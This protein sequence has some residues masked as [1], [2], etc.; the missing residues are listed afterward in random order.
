[1]DEEKVSKQQASCEPYCHLPS[2]PPQIAGPTSPQL[3]PHH[4]LSLSLSNYTTHT[5]TFSTV[6]SHLKMAPARLVWSFDMRLLV[7]IL[8]DPA[9]GLTPAHR[10][11]AFNAVF[12]DQI[13]DFGFGNGIPGR[14]LNAQYGEKKKNNSDWVRIRAS[15]PSAGDVEKRRAMQ[16]QVDSFLLSLQLSGPDDVHSPRRS[17]RSHPAVTASKKR[18]VDEDLDHLTSTPLSKRPAIGLWTPDTPQHPAVKS[19]GKAPSRK[20]VTPKKLS[21]RSKPQ[22]PKVRHTRPDGSTIPVAAHVVIPDTVQ[23]ISQHRA[24]PPLPKLLFRLWR[25]DP[26]QRDSHNGFWSRRHHRKN[27]ISSAPPRSSSIDATDIFDHMDR[28]HVD[29]PFISTSNRLIWMVQQMVTAIK[30][31]S[32]QWHVSVIDVSALDQ[33]GVFWARPFHDEV[34]LSKPFTKGA[35]NYRGTFEFLIWQ[36][37]NISSYPS[38]PHLNTN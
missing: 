5:T 30:T 28:T 2:I 24:Q 29:T 8:Y 27:A 35:G 34:R 12:K 16:A 4:H 36:R 20:P 9:S 33:R 17:A 13:R 11:E 7:D 21:T 38:P 15:S 1:M 6:P 19:M 25:E 31:H 26:S 14:R 3:S 23:S 10:T 22:T 32:R 37:V 18:S